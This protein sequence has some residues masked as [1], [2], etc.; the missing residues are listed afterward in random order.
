MDIPRSD[1]KIVHLDRAKN[2]RMCT[3]VKIHQTVHLAPKHFTIFILCL[4]LQEN[5]DGG[6]VF[7]MK[8]SR[9]SLLDMFQDTICLWISKSLCLW[10][11]NQTAIWFK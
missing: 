11:V 4:N 2:L 6:T 10:I 9:L 3:F 7:Q 5:K 1:E 8:R